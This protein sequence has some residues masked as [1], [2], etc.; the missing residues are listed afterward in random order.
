MHSGGAAHLSKLTAVFPRLATFPMVFQDAYGMSVSTAS[1]NYLSLGIGFVLGLQ[2][3]GPLQDRTFAYCKKHNIDPCASLFD[4]KNWILPHRRVPLSGDPEAPQH[5]QSNADNFIIPRKPV[6]SRSTIHQRQQPNDDPTAALP[7]YR[8][9][10]AMPFSILVP[11]GLSIYGW[12]ARAETHWFIPNMGACI[13][14]FGLIICFN[15]AQ[16]Y[17]VDTY[18]TYAASATGV[19]AF[20]RT[21]AGF[22]FPLFAP[23]MYDKL[24]VGW[25]NSLLAFLSLFIG[26]FAPVMMWRWGAW[27]RSRSTYCIG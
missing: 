22:S 19:A 7:E 26:L 14:A 11:L 20:V 18:T 2:V 13:F 9:P 10:V 15:S 17:V 12:S 25:G 23:A 24:G 16:A 1:L 27:L 6:P 5:V 3:S 21:M 8:L 4:K